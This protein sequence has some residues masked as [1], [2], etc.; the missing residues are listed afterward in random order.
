MSG[1]KNSTQVLKTKNMNIEEQNSV[2]N[3]IKAEMTRAKDKNIWGKPASDIITRIESMENAKPA[4]AIW[5]MVQNARDVSRRHGADIEFSLNEKEFIF[6]HNG[7]PFTADSLNALNIQT[8]SKVR[9]DIVQVGQY[10]TGFLTTHKFGLKFLL[11]GSLELC[12]GSKYFD[13]ERL[14]F[15][16][17]PRDKEKMIENLKDQQRR[18]EEM[19]ENPEDVKYLK[20]IPGELTIFRYLQEHSIESDRAREAFDQAPDLTPH[21]LALNELINSISYKDETTGKESSFSRRPKKILEENDLY[22]FSMVE[23][24]ISRNYDDD[25]LPTREYDYQIFMLESVQKEER[26]GSS[27][28]TVILPLMLVGDEEKIFVF[29]FRDDKPNFFIHLPLLG[30]EKWGVNFLFHSPSFTCADESR[31]SLR[32]VGNGQ[33]NDYQAEQNRE[34]LTLGEQMI[35]D[36]IETHLDKVEDRKMFAYVNIHPEV[37]N[38]KLSEFLKE[39]KSRWVSKMKE[40]KL[41]RPAT[42]GADYVKPSSIY[43]LCKE[44][45]EEGYKNPLFLDAVYNILKTEYA[46]CLPAKDELLFWSER[47]LEWYDGDEGSKHVF[48]IENVVNIITKKND[49]NVLGKDNVLEFD[50]FLAESK[51]FTYFENNAIIPNESGVLKKKS[52]LVCPSSFNKTTREVMEALIPEDFAKFVDSEFADLTQFTSFSDNE[53][54]VKLSDSISKIQEGQKSYKDK[55]RRYTISQSYSDRVDNPESAIISLTKVNAMIKFASMNIKPSSISNE[56]KVLNLIKEYYGFT[57]E[58]TDTL[59]SFEVRSALRTLIGDA[60]YRFTLNPDVCKAEWAQRVVE[61][62]YAYTDIRSMLR[63]YKLYQDQNGNYC[64]AEQLKKENDVPE[65]LKEIYDV[66]VYEGTNKSIKNELL[67]NK[68]M[69]LFEGD[70]ECKGAELSAKI[71]EKIS[72]K[73]E[74]ED[75]SYPDISSYSHR[76][77]VLEIIRRMDESAEGRKWASLFT[78]LEKDKAIVT[79]SIIDDG[80]KKDSIFMF[81]QEEDTNKLKALAEISEKTDVN[82]LKAI[83]DIANADDLPNILATAKRLNDER[84]EK[85]RQFNFKYTIGKIIEDEIRHAVNEELSCSY[86]TSDVQNGQDMIISYKGKPIYFLECKAKWSFTESAHMSS[87]QMKKAVREIGHYALCCV[88]CT[89]DTGAKIPMDASMEEVMDAHDNILAHTYVHT[90]IGELLEPTISPIIKE[91]ELT[92]LDDSNIRVRGELSSYIPKKVFVRGRP[93]YEFMAD[94][95]VQLREIISMEF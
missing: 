74:G 31:S 17:S 6:Q 24:H 52:D 43:G 13:F 33:N 32:F 34:I 1:N 8:S 67:A 79:M 37:S 28:V 88:D 46:S 29:R 14:S 75:K 23:T 22:T 90:N 58:V 20:D 93:F 76:A 39:E 4:R 56:A 92:L 42:E 30:T 44:M 49:L 83:A 19:C 77:E 87:Q 64:Y 80:D 81:M 3:Q 5:E 47:I 53:L 91:E 9:D 40:Y 78:T 85:E 66:I 54:K 51:L 60:M 50:K 25:K 38:V 27:K 94:L 48:T 45:I 62:V 18:I 36:F 86:S 7:L 59:D 10:G 61:T 84:K 73:R 21:V 63:D 68:Y 41:V 82:T 65:R 15:D 70:G 2:I 71:F 72:A 11:S 12:N 16:R 55:Y 35:F 95:N 57:E 26:T 89:P 69:D